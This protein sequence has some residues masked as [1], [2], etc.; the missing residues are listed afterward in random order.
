MERTGEIKGFFDLWSVYDRVLD[1]DYM[2]HREL[3]AKVARV[4]DARFGAREI[5]VLELGCGSGRHLAPVLAARRV[6]RYEGHDLSPVAIGHARKNFAALGV[7]ETRFVEGDLMNALRDETGE[8]ADLIFS[9]FTLHHLSAEDRAEAI[10]RARGRLAPGGLLLV[11]DSMREEGQTRDAWLDAYCGWIEAEWTAI[12]AEGK[13]AIFGH[14][15]GCDQPGTRA[16]HDTAAK[17]AGFA[18]CGEIA[19]RRWHVLWS[20]EQGR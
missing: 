10:R 8:R 9:G 16:E 14:I 13:A 19:R 5:S 20:A 7:V 2:F 18:R 12:P 4:L 17:A 11:L 15:R 3:Y 1:L 6:G